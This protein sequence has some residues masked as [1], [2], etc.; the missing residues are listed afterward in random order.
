M[1]TSQVQFS[2]RVYQVSFRDRLHPCFE[3]Q[4]RSDPHMI[5]HTAQISSVS[6][7]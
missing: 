7:V 5:S 1:S 3:I 6:Y 4:E 2:W